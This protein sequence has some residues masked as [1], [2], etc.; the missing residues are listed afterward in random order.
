MSRL[1]FDKDVEL[2]PQGRDRYRRLLALVY[3]ENVDVG[4][5][6]L[7][8]GLAW[9]FYRYLVGA[10]AEVQQVILPLGIGLASNG[11]VFLAKRGEIASFHSPTDPEG[12]IND[13]EAGSLHSHASATNPPEDATP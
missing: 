7:A 9:P 13:V 10:P 11:W 1:V 8:A 4:L 2:R 5:E 12:A 6:L 3:V